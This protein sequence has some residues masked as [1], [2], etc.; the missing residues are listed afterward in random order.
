MALRSETLFGGDQPRRAGR[1]GGQRLVEIGDDVVDMLDADA[2]AGSSPASRRPWRCSSA[3][4]WRCVV[5]AGWQA[6]DLASPI[7]TSRLISF[8]A[9]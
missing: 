1:R 9:S 4:I 3:D 7:L 8:S 6:S 5:E 2:T